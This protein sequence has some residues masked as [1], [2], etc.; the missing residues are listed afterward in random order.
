MC[1]VICF[2]GFI[3]DMRSLKGDF[4]TDVLCHFQPLSPTLLW[5]HLDSKG[6]LCQISDFSYESHSNESG[7]RALF[8]DGDSL[9]NCDSCKKPG[10]DR[11]RPH[12]NLHI[13]YGS[14]DKWQSVSDGP[15]SSLFFRRM[16]HSCTWILFWKFSH[17]HTQFLSQFDKDIRTANN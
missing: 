4:H 9:S 2:L 5:N 10:A 1:L 8:Y 15:F 16:I 12:V 13:P 3:H 14:F 6:C 17:S 11:F 7:L